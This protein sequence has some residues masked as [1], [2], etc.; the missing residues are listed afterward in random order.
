[1]FCRCTYSYIQFVQRKMPPLSNIYK[2][3]PYRLSLFHKNSGLFS[4]IIFK[5]HPLLLHMLTLLF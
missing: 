1:M 3:K 2:T 5:I 4:T